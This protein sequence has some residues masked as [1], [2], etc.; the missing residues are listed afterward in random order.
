MKGKTMMK[1]LSYEDLNAAYEDKTSVVRVEAVFATEMVGGMPAGEEGVR[2]FVAH[3][4]HLEGD[5]AEQAVKRIMS[6]ELQDVTP[7]EGELPEGKMYGLRSLR[8][9]AHG[10]W[11]GDW[12]VKANIKNSASRLD[13]FKS[14]KGTK[15][16][17]AEAGRVR[18]WKYSLQDP[19]NPQHIYIRN[20]ADAPCHTRH[21]NFMGRVQSPRGPVSIIHQS[22]VVEAG[23]RFAYEFRF[24]KGKIVEG[25][26]R[27]ILAL[28]MIVGIGSARSLERGKFRIEKAEIEL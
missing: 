15:G 5:E 24:I 28:S 2:Q 27:D 3:H 11:I 6:E 13:I 19:D 1:T 14:I 7:A 9:G 17:F 8:R 16:N 25:D 10:P 4:L 22:E 23:S 26:V 21:E 18:A 20:S 12:M